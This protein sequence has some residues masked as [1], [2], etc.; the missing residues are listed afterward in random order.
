MRRLIS[1]GVW[2]GLA[3]LLLFLA[4]CASGATA[5]RPTALPPRPAGATPQV[6]GRAGGDVTS[7]LGAGD[8]AFRAGDLAT[9]EQEHRSALALDPASTE[10]NFGLGNVYL[11]AARLDEA[12]AA[13]EAA[14]R[15]DPGQLNARADLG[16]VY[17]QMGDYIKAA[18]QYNL[19]LEANPHDAQSLYLLAAVRLQEQNLPEAEQLLFKARDARPDLPE[20]YYGLGALYQLQG[21]KDQ[22]IANFEKFLQIG[23]GQDPAAKGYAEQQLELL[24]GQ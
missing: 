22:A 15:A 16:V 13:Y 24:R 23:P 21:K 12:Q 9:V 14:L 6:S 18:E 4:G 20:T 17:Y 3:G 1:S 2:V 7:H 8:A 11:R 19:V 10:A 5:G